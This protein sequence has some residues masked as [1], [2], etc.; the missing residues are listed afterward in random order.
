MLTCS[1]QV[2]R[3]VMIRSGCTPKPVVALPLTSEPCLN[4]CK[5]MLQ[6]PENPKHRRQ[7][8]EVVGQA[9]KCVLCI[10]EEVLSH[11]TRQCIVKY[12]GLGNG[13]RSLRV[14]CLGPKMSA[15]ACALTTPA[16]LIE[17][18]RPGLA[19]RSHTKCT[20]NSR[21][22]RHASIWICA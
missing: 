10:A 19:L 16:L 8:D 6:R 3:K 2:S 21:L 12:R 14:V 15:I 4:L 22:C 5:N 20:R 13:L 17:T 18:K 1:H 7:V 11:Q 9:P